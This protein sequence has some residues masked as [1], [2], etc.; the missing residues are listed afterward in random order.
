[1]EIDLENPVAL[2]NLGLAYEKRKKYKEAEEMFKKV[3]EM[4]PDSYPAYIRLSNIYK[5]TNEPRKAINMSI[6]YFKIYTKKYD[7]FSER[8]L[9]NL[10]ELY[11]QVNYSKEAYTIL[12]EVLYNSPDK[13]REIFWLGELYEELNKTDEALDLFKAIIQRSP[14][15]YAAY[16]ELA[17]YY[18]NNNRTEEAEEIFSKLKEID[19]QY[20]LFAYEEIRNRYKKRSQFDKSDEIFNKGLDIWTNDD[21]ITQQNYLKLYRMLHEREIKIIVMQYPTVNIN[22]LKNYFRGDEDIVFVSNEENFNKAL[23]NSSYDE[24]FID[25]FKG[26]YAYNTKIQQYSPKKFGHAT[27]RGNKLIAENVANEV[28]KM[29]EAKQS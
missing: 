17:F 11:I 14:D 2:Y 13:E 21:R 5:Y 19:L 6:N 23:E 29:V 9:I 20:P 10:A 25:S 18:L 12:R 15:N 24:Y 1:M 27:K 7:E 26:K 22:E 16:T 4:R 3:I 28:L 8:E